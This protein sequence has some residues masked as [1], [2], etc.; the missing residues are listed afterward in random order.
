MQTTT[1]EIPLGHEARF[2]YARAVYLV[3][4][5]ELIGHPS[6]GGLANESL[7]VRVRVRARLSASTR[8]RVEYAKS[9]P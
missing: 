3:V 9:S 8:A 6:R 4:W 1:M 2:I 5:A 7:C